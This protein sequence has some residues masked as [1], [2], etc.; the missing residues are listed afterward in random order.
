MLSFDKG[1]NYLT[2]NPQGTK[3]VFRQKG[4]LWLANIDGTD[5]RQITTS[6]TEGVGK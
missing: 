5:L 2:V 6:K 3:L 4:H 1:I